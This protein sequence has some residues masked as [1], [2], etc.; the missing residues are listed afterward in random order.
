MEPAPFHRDVAEAPETGQT[1]W[2]RTGDRVRIRVGFWPAVGEAPGRGS[3]LILPGRSEFIEKYG[4]IVTGFLARGFAVGVID[5]RGQGLSDR[6]TTDP[7]LG[8]VE[9][10]ADYMDD[11]R[12]FVAAAEEFGLRAPWHFVAHSMGGL[13]GLRAIHEGVDVR[14][15]VFSA[16][17]WGLMM[18]P[19]LSGPVTWAISSAS[20][21][22]GLAERYS[23]GTGPQSYLLT[24][25]FR[26]NTLTSD[27]ESYAYILRQIAMHPELAIGGPSIHWLNEALIEARSLARLDPPDHEALVYLGS[28]ESVVEIP[29]LRDTVSRWPRAEL[30]VIAGAR[31]E[32]F[33]ES[34]GVRQ[35]LMT[36]ID[37]FLAA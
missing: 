15:S 32:I 1:F 16:P 19:A 7:R 11:L 6:L 9:R 34:A 36:E 21:P 24:S 26:G 29:T 20:R 5:W 10:F 35:L 31:H 28:D 25:G 22:L 30:R 23:P 37:S 14:K 4:R 18:P 12:V 2:L 8:H 33:M 13:I 17:M 3:I 27:P